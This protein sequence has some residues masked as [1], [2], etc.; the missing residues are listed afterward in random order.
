MV[1]VIG[2]DSKMNKGADLSINYTP[3]NKLED[4]SHDINQLR[5][6]QFFLT[7]SKV[8]RKK[9]FIPK[10]II[11]HAGGNGDYSKA[12]L[13]YSTLASISIVAEPLFGFST[14]IT[15]SLSCGARASM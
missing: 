2:E 5:G 11:A 14:S 12:K 4:F 6:P 7:D 13:I 8:F 10:K 3:I 15:F 9:D 1:V